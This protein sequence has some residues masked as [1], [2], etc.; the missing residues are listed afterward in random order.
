[1]ESSVT[2]GRVSSSMISTMSSPLSR[3]ARRNEAG[4]CQ[5][6]IHSRSAMWWSVAVTRSYLVDVTRV[7]ETGSVLSL[8]GPLTNR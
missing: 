7:R 3:Q 4:V 5:W 2:A 6:M 8:S 1:V